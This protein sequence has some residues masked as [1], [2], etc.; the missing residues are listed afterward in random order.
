MGR[1]ALFE[2][3]QI[4]ATP[5]ALDLM[6]QCQVSGLSLLARHITGDW[7]DIDPADRG[8]NEEALREGYRILSVYGKGD[9]RIWIITE[10]DRSV[11]TLLLPDDY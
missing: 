2:L 6:E 8:L 10:A 3:G 11:T 5:G 1:K 7:G 9:E 4:V